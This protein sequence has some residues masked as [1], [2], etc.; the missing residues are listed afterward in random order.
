M[1]LSTRS[2]SSGVPR[3]ER[4]GADA[5]ALGL[6]RRYK[7]SRDEEARRAL[8]L[9][10]APLVGRTL[11]RM[12]RQL[13]SH[14]ERSELAS[15]GM[16]GLIDAIEKFR[17]DLGIKFETYATIRI[18]GAILDHL[19]AMD[20]LPRGLRRQARALEDA[21]QALEHGLGRKPTEGEVAAQMGIQLRRLHR[22]LRDLHLGT[23][24]SLESASEGAEAGE[25]PL[26]EML[27]D[28]GGGPEEAVIAAD[29]RWTL[30]RG[31]ARLAD[32]D[33]SVLMLYYFEGLTLR[34]VGSTLGLSEAAIC[35][36]HGQALARLRSEMQR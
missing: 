25:I 6:W 11:D 33:R 9:V 28:P 2:R 30:S 13:S 8:I 23:F 35:S 19:R 12:A 7:Q 5:S 1:A 22:L 21:C 4:A 29:E 27:A 20:W 18:Q 16:I 26:R 32:R 24:V 15:C 3:P 36:I 31:L 17:T 34:Q 14:L 10:Y